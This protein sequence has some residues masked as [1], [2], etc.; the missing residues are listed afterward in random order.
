MNK[1][2]KNVAAGSGV[3]SATS[4]VLRDEL[5]S[6]TRMIDAPGS[7]AVDCWMD[8][9]TGYG[10]RFIHGHHLGDAVEVYQRF[11]VEGLWD[12]AKH[13]GRDF[14][15]PHGLPL[16]GAEPAVRLLR[17]FGIDVPPGV[18]V[19]WL[20]ANVVDIMAASSAG[21]TLYLVYRNRAKPTTL[22][23]GAGIK[24]AVGI[25]TTNPVM[26]CGAIL[27]GGACVYKLLNPGS[28]SSESTGPMELGLAP[29]L[30]ALTREVPMVI[31]DDR[32]G[33]LLELTR[34]LQVSPRPV[35]S[36]DRSERLRN[37]LSKTTPGNGNDEVQ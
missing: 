29:R 22:M 16:P 32:Y 12:F 26:V 1:L 24:L 18:T 13:L 33:R 28:A 4:S 35:T 15:T 23:V 8:G 21:L 36:E 2:S 37:L 3:V 30:L 17:D 10:H 19:D 27:A 25:A 14:C 34:Q 9:V 7:T 20:C 11:G 5:S 6:V 31:S